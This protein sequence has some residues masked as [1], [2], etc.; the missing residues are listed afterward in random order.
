[1]SE[2]VHGIG[3]GIIVSILTGSFFICAMLNEIAKAIH[4]HKAEK[5]A[6]EKQRAQ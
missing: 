2:D 5:P 4:E 3:L 6:A 1:M